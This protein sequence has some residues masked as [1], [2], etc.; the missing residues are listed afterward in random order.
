MHL[1]IAAVLL[2]L[3]GLVIYA[4]ASGPRL[5]PET[6]AIIEDVLHGELPEVI[7]GQTGF[8]SSSGLDTWYESMLPE[9]S[10]KGAVLLLMA[11]GGDALIWPPKF[12]RALVHASG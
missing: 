3:A 6:D 12:V 10:S 9:G 4:Y 7:V 11:N 2:L 1:V 8:A 5:P